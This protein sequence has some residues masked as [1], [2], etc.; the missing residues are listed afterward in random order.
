MPKKIPPLPENFHVPKC[1]GGPQHRVTA[2]FG[3][4]FHEIE[5]N[6]MTSFME[7][8]IHPHIHAFCNLS[9][10]QKT[11][12]SLV[13]MSLVQPAQVCL[14]QDH[15]TPLLKN[16]A[17]D[18]LECPRAQCPMGPTLSIVLYLIVAFLMNALLSVP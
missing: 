2:S 14:A 10:R 15:S 5:C 18:L 17:Q 3:V 8:M 6:G 13:P 4:F 7:F 16:M 1:L 12:H 9:I 11:A